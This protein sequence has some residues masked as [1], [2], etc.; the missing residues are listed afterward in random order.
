MTAS[1]RPAALALLTVL[2]AL[3]APAPAGAAETVP[4]EV[5]VKF[6]TGATAAAASRG[7]EPVGHPR[8]LRVASVPAALAR[9]RARPDVVYAVPN[10]KARIAGFMP[11][12]PGRGTTPGGWADVQ[13]NFAGPFGVNAPDAWQRMI[14]VGRPG[15]RGGEHGG[16]QRQE[17]EGGG[18]ERGGHGRRGVR[19]PRAGRGS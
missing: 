19:T 1:L 5:V 15:G 8:T 17:G 7:P 14:E 10:V 18:A 13:W 6:R 9:L 3:A 11:N 2:V 12:D 4:G 16:E